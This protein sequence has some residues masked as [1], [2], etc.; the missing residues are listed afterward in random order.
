MTKGLPKSASVA[1]PMEGAK[2]HAPAAARNARFLCDLLERH[3]P[4]SGEALEIASGTGQHIVAFA[5]ALPGLMWQPTE[6]DDTRR[7]S[8]DAYGAEADLPNL[9]P[10]RL[11]D[12]TRPD[13]HRAEPPVDLIVLV[14]LLHLIDDT[15]TEAL[16]QQALAALRPGG[17]FIAYGPFKRAGVLTSPGDKRFDADLRAADPAIGY[18]DDR[19]IIRRLATAGAASVQPI[20]MPANNLAFVATKA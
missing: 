1:T 7:A 13:W 10:A 17:R 6:V 16:L 3:A 11:L 4:P 5:K 9:R 14:N 12:A 8:I 2:L 18:K 19:D 15:A 20:D